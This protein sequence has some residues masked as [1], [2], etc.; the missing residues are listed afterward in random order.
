MRPISPPKTPIAPSRRFLLALTLLLL[1]FL[2]YTVYHS[3]NSNTAS[4]VST[5]SPPSFFLSLSPSSNASISRDLRSLTLRPHVAGTPSAASTTSFVLSRLRSAGLQTFSRKYSPLLSFPSHASLSLHHPNGSLIALLSLSEPADPNGILVP[6]YHAYSPSGET[7]APAVYANLGR[8]ED[9][10]MLDRLGLSVNGC[11][12]LVRKGGGYRGGIV[13]RAAE[14]GAKA[15]LIA[16]GP[17]GGIERGTVILGGPGDPL[18]PGWGAISSV[19]RGRDVEK[20]EVTAEEVV[21]RFPKIPSMPVAAVTAAEILRT[22]GGPALPH[23]WQEGLV[24]TGGGVG[25]GPT[26][27]NFTYTVWFLSECY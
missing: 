22:L 21:R 8:E 5:T 15:V 27:I 20:L 2:L 19:S 16:G 14:R 26:L 23:E 1:F 11:V 25:P 18:T 24:E 12:V 6:P 7:L 4:L 10:Q 17:D 9:F 13:A 3:F